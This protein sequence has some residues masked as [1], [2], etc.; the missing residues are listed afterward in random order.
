[1]HAGARRCSSSGRK[2]CASINRAPGSLT[3]NVPNPEWLTDPTSSQLR[4]AGGTRSER[5]ASAD[6]FPGAECAAADAGRGRPLSGDLTEHQQHAPGSDPRRLRRAHHTACCGD[7]TRTISARPASWADYFSA[8]R[9]PASPAPTRV[10]QG[11]SAAFGVRSMIGSNKLNELNYHFSSNNITTIPAEG[12]RNTK[13]DY[14]LTTREVF[15]ENANDLIPIIEITGLSLLGG[16]QLFRIQYLNH[17]I[18]DNFSWQKRQPCVQ[19]WRLGDVRAEKRERRECQPWPMG[20]RGYHWRPHRVPKLPAW[21]CQRGVRG[22]Q[23][24][25]G[26]TR[27]RHAV[28]VQSLRVLRPGHV[29]APRRCHGGLR[30]AL[31]AVPAPHRQQQPA[32]HLR[33]VGLFR[34]R[35]A[36]VCQSCGN[37]DRSAR[38]ATCWSASS[39]AASIRRTATAFTNSRRTRFNRAS[40][41]RGICQVTGDDRAAQRVWRVLRPAARRHL[42][43][44]LI[45]HP[46]DRQQH[47]VHQPNARQPGSRADPHDHRRPRDS[48]DGHGLRKPAH[49]AVERGCDAPARVMGERAKSAT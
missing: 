34:R 38:Q 31:F 20:I 4:A 1:M 12:V 7:A 33:A 48:G 30:S 17:S 49:D 43:A 10:F 26:R 13:A 27:Y 32:G 29:A 42:R 5:G 3:A 11:R 22:V 15:P 21:Q 14:G 16:N 37:L 24:H 36:A 28:A 19:I 45:Y 44:E 40:V 41:W 18:T 23:L 2:S 46:A 9:C 35:R 39:R 47:H 6:G 25:R 8:R